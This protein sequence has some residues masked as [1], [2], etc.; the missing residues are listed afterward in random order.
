MKEVRIA[1][2]KDET[3][4]GDRV[5]VENFKLANLWMSRR[6]QKQR[7]RGGVKRLA[8]CGGDATHGSMFHRAPAVSAAVRSRLVGRICIF[9]VT[10]GTRK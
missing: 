7:V 3:K 4:V 6:Q 9:R 8:L 5:L 1:E 2:S 10:W